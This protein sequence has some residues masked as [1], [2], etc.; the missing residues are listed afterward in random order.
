LLVGADEPQSEDGGPEEPIVGPTRLLAA[1]SSVVA[2]VHLATLA[3]LV[4]GH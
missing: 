2:A 4:D 3:V 1:L